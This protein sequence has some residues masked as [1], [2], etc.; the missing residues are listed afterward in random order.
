M[1]AGMVNTVAPKNPSR[2]LANAADLDIPYAM[3]V[4]GVSLT[5]H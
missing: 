2:T 5:Y 3:S 4:F 1:I